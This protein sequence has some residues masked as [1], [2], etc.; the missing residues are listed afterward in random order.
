MSLT[1]WL[2]I[3]LGGASLPVLLVQV[4][5]PPRLRLRP[6][7]LIIDGA[8]NQKVVRWRDIDA[9][10]L[11]RLSAAKYPALRYK[12]G[13][14]PAGR[15]PGGPDQAIAAPWPLKAEAMVDVL[16]QCRQELVGGA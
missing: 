7:V 6:D 9:F 15:R 1:G 2:A 14:A 8:F 16:N 3:F 4:L 13:R 11:G 5:R 12:T 10:Y